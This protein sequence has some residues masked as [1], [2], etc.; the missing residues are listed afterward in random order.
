M[1]TQAS[2]MRVMETEP[3]VAAKVLFNLSLILCERLQSTNR[4]VRDMS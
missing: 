1:L 3:A 4:L 2:L